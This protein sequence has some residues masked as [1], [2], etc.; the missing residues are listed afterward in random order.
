MM[1]LSNTHPSVSGVSTSI[2]L[3]FSDEKFHTEL[4]Y[5]STTPS[6]SLEERRK[7]GDNVERILA[8]EKEAARAPPREG[9]AS[10]KATNMN[11]NMDAG[12]RSA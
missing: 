9:P 2:S 6:F 12:V 10:F 7:L 1:S 11:M 3:V 8:N 5:S 4:G